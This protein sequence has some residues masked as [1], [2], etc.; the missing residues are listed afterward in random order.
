MIVIMDL[1]GINEHYLNTSIVYFYTL[2]E[3]G[4]SNE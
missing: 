2:I 3:K 4:R 1:M